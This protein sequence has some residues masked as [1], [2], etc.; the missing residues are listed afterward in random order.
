MTQVTDPTIEQ[1]RAWLAGQP[2]SDC[3]GTGRVPA[4]PHLSPASGF[5][6]C[7]PGCKGTGRAHPWASKLCHLCFGTSAKGLP[8]CTTVLEGGC[9]GSGR[10]PKAL[11]LEELLEVASGIVDCINLNLR[12]GKWECRL[13]AGHMKDFWGQGETPLL[14]ALR[15]VAKQ[16]GMR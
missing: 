15:A 9:N 11:G 8:T 7:R 10:V 16:A 5:A 4:A 3:G 2:C 12:Q 14:A 13:M 6:L 1:I